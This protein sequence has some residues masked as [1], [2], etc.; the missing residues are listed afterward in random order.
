MYSHCSTGEP[1]T[2]LIRRWQNDRAI[3]GPDNAGGLPGFVA[4]LGGSRIALGEARF[5]YNFAVSFRRPGEDA[6]GIG[7]GRTERGLAAGLYG[8]VPLPWGLV[9]E[10]LVEAVRQDSAGGFDGRRAE[11][12]TAGLAVTAGALTASH[13]VMVRRDADDVARSRAF[14]RQHT[15]NVTLALGHATGF[16]PLNPF[17]V[18]VDWRRLAEGRARSEGFAAGVAFSLDF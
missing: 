6:T 11:W 18:L 1:V 4:S 8:R 3:G 14:A 9:A 2:R 12:L 16:A 13:A 15:A 5:G 7:R 17:S 10:P